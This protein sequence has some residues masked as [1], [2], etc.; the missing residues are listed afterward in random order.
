MPA[1]NL[2]P[3]LGK[4]SGND[5]PASL[6]SSSDKYNGRARTLL[7]V[8]TERYVSVWKSFQTIYNARIR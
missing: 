3:E 1:F 2:L 5:R 6:E 8:R 7:C 4:L